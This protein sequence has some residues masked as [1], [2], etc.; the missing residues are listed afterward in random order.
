MA[1]R[2][3]AASRRSIQ[4]VSCEVMEILVLFGIMAIILLLIDP[5]LLGILELLA[6]IFVVAFITLGG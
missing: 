1:D 4:A 3:Q 5:V 6:V 2:Y